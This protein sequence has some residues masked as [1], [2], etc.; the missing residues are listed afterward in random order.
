[1]NI[2]IDAL[3]QNQIEYTIDQLFRMLDKEIKTV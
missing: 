2:E 3:D 1:M